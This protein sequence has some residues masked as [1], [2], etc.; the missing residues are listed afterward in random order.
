M[1]GYNCTERLPLLRC[2][3]GSATAAARSPMPRML[4]EMWSSCLE[5]LGRAYLDLGS[6]SEE[7]R[8]YQALTDQI[9]ALAQRSSG[10]SSH[11]ILGYPDENG[12]WME[13]EC[14]RRS[15]ASGWHQRSTRAEREWV[16][17]LQID[18]NQ[19]ERDGATN[20][21][22]GDW[23]AISFWIRREALARRHVEQV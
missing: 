15:K 8:R 20:M 23:L 3:K 22:K 18:A 14:E 7:W 16:L 1:R 19:A 2:L 13:G 9:D 6:D 21:G 10:P 17:L 11:R 12:D 4:P 5:N